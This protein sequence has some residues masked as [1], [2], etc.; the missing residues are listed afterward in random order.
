MSRKQRQAR[1]CAILIGLAAT[2]VV[3]AGYLR[4]GLDRLEWI[5]LDLR[6]R[7]ANSIAPAEEIV[8]LDITDRDLELVGRGICRRR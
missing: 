7:H 1:L 8:C 3:L 4:G 5:T 2:T 6:F